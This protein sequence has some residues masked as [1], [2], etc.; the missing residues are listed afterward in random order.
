[1]K[2]TFCKNWPILHIGDNI[3][4]HPIYKQIAAPQIYRLRTDTRIPHHPVTSG[5]VHFTKHI[6]IG[7]GLIVDISIG[8]ERCK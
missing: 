7:R 6:R 8:S 4:P 1:M 5:A 3:E 2:C